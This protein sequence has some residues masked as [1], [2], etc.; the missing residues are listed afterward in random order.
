[1]KI[2]TP[3]SSH[4]RCSPMQLASRME[5]TCITAFHFNKREFWVHKTSLTPPPF[6]EVSVPSLES[7]RSCICVLQISILPLRIFYG[8]FLELFWRCI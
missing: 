8:F 6:I 1:L 4:Q 7:E 3:N 2:N 5:S